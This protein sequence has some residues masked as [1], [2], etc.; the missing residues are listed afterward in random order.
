MLPGEALEVALEAGRPEVAQAALLG[1]VDL[2]RLQL[3]RAVP[4]YFRNGH[5][6]PRHLQV[7]FR[8]YGNFSFDF[9]FLYSCDLKSG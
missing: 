5:R 4:V 1:F 7:P 9:L 3:P 8:N 6:I 2:P